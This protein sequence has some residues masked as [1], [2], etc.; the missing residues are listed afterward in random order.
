MLKVDEKIIKLLKE[1]K[2]EDKQ[3]ILTILQWENNKR[4]SQKRSVKK[5]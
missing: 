4:L 3:R 2:K 5:C 1:T